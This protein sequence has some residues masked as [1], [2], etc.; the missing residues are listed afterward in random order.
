MWSRPSNKSENDNPALLTIDRLTEKL[1]NF[2]L[3][4]AVRAL[5]VSEAI[6]RVEEGT[7]HPKWDGF[8]R[9]IEVRV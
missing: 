5:W 3:S 8:I 7:F 6:N 2:E 4:S 9:L 1:K